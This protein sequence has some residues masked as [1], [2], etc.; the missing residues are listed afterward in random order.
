MLYL[1][2]DLGGTNIAAGIVNENY[3]IIKKASTPTNAS[4]DRSADDITADIAALCKKY[5]LPTKESF[6]FEE[7]A[8]A[9]RSDKK[10]AGDSISL[11][12]LREIG[13]SFT[14]KIELDKLEEFIA[15][16]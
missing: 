12:L 13:D 9:A 11:V 3:E 6:G 5:S 4:P 7:L 15:A 2:I 1:G 10:S 16:E 8:N 14:Q